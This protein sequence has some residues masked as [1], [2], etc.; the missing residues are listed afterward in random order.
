MNS[1]KS[2]LLQINANSFQK[3]QEHEDYIITKNITYLYTYGR[4]LVPKQTPD[5]KKKA[6]TELK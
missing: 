3:I 5:Q 2:S 6:K 1:A 4:I